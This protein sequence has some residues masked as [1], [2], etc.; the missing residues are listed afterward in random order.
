V[1]SNGCAAP[2]VGACIASGRR[3]DGVGEIWS[4]RG[5]SI[6]NAKHDIENVIANDARR[7]GP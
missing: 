2:I 7:R 1:R 5:P 3:A 6:A 4:T